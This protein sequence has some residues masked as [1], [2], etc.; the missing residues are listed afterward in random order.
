MCSCG[1]FMK[2]LQPE[3][4]TGISLDSATAMSLDSGSICA[5]II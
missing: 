5:C 3:Y 1:M 4:K 2:T